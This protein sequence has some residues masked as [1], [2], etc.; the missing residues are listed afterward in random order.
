VLIVINMITPSTECLEVII[1]V[2][3]YLAHISS[4]L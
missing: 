4:A 3:N 2:T 1:G